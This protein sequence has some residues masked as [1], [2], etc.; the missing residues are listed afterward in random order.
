MAQ[1]MVLSMLK[2][3]LGPYVKDLNEDNFQ[4]D[5][6]GG[7]IE[8]DDLELSKSGLALL[9]LPVDIA[10]S[11]LGSMR[12]TI[13]W[14]HLS[15]EPVIV[16]IQE[17]YLVATPKSPQ[18]LSPEEIQKQIEERIKAKMSDIE[19][20]EK[21]RMATSH[22]DDSGYFARLTK[23]VIDNIQIEVDKIHIR[24]EY[25]VR[26]HQNAVIME[27]FSFCT[28]SCT[29]R[30]ASFP[31]FSTAQ[32]DPSKPLALGLKLDK[33]SVQ[34]CDENWKQTFVPTHPEPG[35]QLHQ[36]VKLEKFSVCAHKRTHSHCRPSE[37]DII[38]RRPRSGTMML[39]V[40]VVYGRPCDAGI[41]RN[42]A[43]STSFLGPSVL[44]RTSRS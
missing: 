13:P 10:S 41:S 35:E 25:L 14:A 34:S 37:A 27:C 42:R 19:S 15:S 31:E 28:A 7:V 5:L 44:A 9:D 26:E 39:I 12:I 43:R 29:P 2:E 30:L 4:A 24:L 8:F 36:M 23:R 17:I 22:E 38:E 6:F 32:D 21:L 20:N 40:Q 18:K 3:S 16:Q 33:I 1:S 11:H